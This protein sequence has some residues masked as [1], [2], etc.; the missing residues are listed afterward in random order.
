MIRIIFMIIGV[1]IGSSIWG[2]D[3]NI[4]LKIVATLFL[5]L[6]FFM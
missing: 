1:M 5:V 4:I 3:W 2:T 6:P